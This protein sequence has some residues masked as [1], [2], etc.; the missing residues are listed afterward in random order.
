[1]KRGRLM[2][3]AEEDSEREDW[4]KASKHSNEEDQGNVETGI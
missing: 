4:M 3:K 1:M 2:G